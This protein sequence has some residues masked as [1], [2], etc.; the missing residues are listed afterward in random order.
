M[1][2]APTAKVSIAGNV[3]A[4][5]SHGK[6]EI[7]ASNE[8]VEVYF[9]SEDALR[10]IAVKPLMKHFAKY[11]GASS[12]LEAEIRIF[13]KNSLWLA[14]RNGKLSVK[15]PFAAGLFFIRQWLFG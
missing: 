9:S 1:A 5:S 4:E 13:V 12:F 3:T 6:I 15:R 8:Y 14:V 11:R 2:E 10:A 7:K